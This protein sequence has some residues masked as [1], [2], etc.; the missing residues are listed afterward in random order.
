MRVNQVIAA[1]VLSVHVA[2]CAHWKPVQALS[3]AANPPAASHSQLSSGRHKI[4]ITLQTGERI[5]MTPGTVRVDSVRGRVWAGRTYVDSSVA[6]TDVVRIE[7]TV[8]NVG[9]TILLVVT[10]LLAAAGLYVVIVGCST[11]F[12]TAC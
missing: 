12:I 7:R 5:V 6:R 4:R 9:G 11:D 2:G 1:V 8:A 10:G 3:P